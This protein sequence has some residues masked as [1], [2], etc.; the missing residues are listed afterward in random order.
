MTNSVRRI[1]DGP[2]LGIALILLLLVLW[3]LAGAFKWVSPL[4]LPRVSLVLSTLWDLVRSGELP[5]EP[6]ASLWRMS[7]G[8]F[9]GVAFGVLLGLPMGAFRPM[10]N[11]LEPIT[12]ILRPIPSPAYAPIAILFLGIDDE[13]KILWWPSR[14]SF[15]SCSTPIGSPKRRSGT[16]PDR[17]NLRRQRR[18]STVAGRAAGRRTF[19][20]R[21]Q[22]RGPRGERRIHEPVAGPEGPGAAAAH[23]I[24]GQHG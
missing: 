14:R 5:K 15:P 1:A 16:D 13:M 22:C 21:E 24:F 17:E 18:A 7:A 8:Y 20:L 4:S 10:Y 11:L 12:E 9:I 3:E 23:G 6:I 19:H 2:R